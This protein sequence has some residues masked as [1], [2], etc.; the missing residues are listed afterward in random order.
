MTGD[1]LRRPGV[2]GSF[3]PG[4][5]AALEAEVAR[6]LAGAE[7]R[8]PPLP[9]PPVAVISPHAGY[10]FSGALTAAALAARAGA[11]PRRIAILSP[12]HRH[13]FRGIALPSA[14]GYRLPGDRRI[15]IDTGAR[16]AALTAGLA[17]LRDA[18]HEMEHGI[19][20]Q[21]PFLA[22]LYPEAQV[23]PVVIGAAETGAVAALIDLLAG[24]EGGT[25]F[26]LSSDLSHFHTD[27]D[28]KRRDAETAR[29]IETGDHAH[30]EP[31]DACGARGI[32]GYLASRTGGGARALRLGMM[33]SHAA[34]GDAGR[35]VGY[36]AWA[37]HRPGDAM[38]GAAER[39]D[40]LRAARGALVRRTRTGKAAEVT[41]DGIGPRLST[42]AASFVTLE[43]GTPGTGW[44][45]RGCVGSL[46]AQAPLMRDV[47]EN[48]VKAGFSDPRFAPLGAEELARLR[49][50]VSVLSRPAPLAF[51]SEEEAL[52]ALV[53]GESGAILSDGRHRGLFLPQVWDSLPEPRAFLRG[54]RRKAGLAEDHWSGT[55]RL[56]LFRAEAFGEA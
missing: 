30:L 49:I 22:A 17:T 52:A 31:Q 5:G 12:A 36:G 32:A 25:F 16:Q 7:R 14:A 50:K 2:A 26:V 37:F 47:A 13:A 19:E 29:K 21:L 3:F 33:N 46:A 42:H 8:S 51:A 10:R 41:P 53:P 11:A 44:R 45:L 48:A 43:T 56:E 20:T 23:L 4:E 40:L 34:G 18:A 55:T 38:L 24:L 28:A 15:A 9:S 1:D 6:L 54:L 35:V 39:A 27:P